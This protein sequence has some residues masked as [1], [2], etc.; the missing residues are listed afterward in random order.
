MIFTGERGEEMGT[1]ALPLKLA[2]VISYGVMITANT[3]A[4]TL[5][6]NG[7]TTGAVSDAYANLFAPAGLTFSIWGL[8]Y[9]L[10]A[11]FVFFQLGLVPSLCRWEIIRR[12]GWLFAL[13]S[14]VNAA[15]IFAWHYQQFLLSV[16]LMLILLTSLIRIN[17][18][19]SRNLAE[20]LSLGAKLIVRLPFSIYFGWITVA[21]IANITV[22][23]VST[24]WNRCGLPEVLWTIIIILVGAAIGIATLWR[25]RDIAYGLTIVWAYS[26]IILKHSTADGF[27]G[28]YP[29][30]IV[31]AG[32]A[33]AGILAAIG[34]LFKGPSKSSESISPQ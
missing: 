6:I 32:V 17:T 33:I 15:W 24:G 20:P 14:L 30:I 27:A 28:A 29:S 11:I 2:I 7:L 1:H 10:L 18:I 21:T 22:L 13:S 9:L 25:N 5:P 26:G 31:A 4:N 8:I 3:L 23:L 19:L 12:I 34:L 16:G